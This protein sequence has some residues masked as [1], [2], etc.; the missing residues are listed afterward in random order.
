[1]NI[2]DTAYS[3]RLL[4]QRLHE[5]QNVANLLESIDIDAL[6]GAEREAKIRTELARN[7]ASEVEAK[8]V[9]AAAAL[10]DA[11]A[12]TQRVMADA[13]ST[14]SRLVQE[15]K[16]NAARIVADAIAQADTAKER[17]AAAAKE[18]EELTMRL[19]AAKYERARILQ[20]S[21]T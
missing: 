8:L 1:M 21:A 13:E 7:A 11:E 16:D 4:A 20:A 17:A 5:I 6:V 9:D 3:M 18:L 2:K 10:K 15:A 19:A 12:Q 14:A